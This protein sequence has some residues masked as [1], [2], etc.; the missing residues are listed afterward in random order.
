MLGG[1]GCLAF[2]G[3]GLA[4]A[5]SG[6]FDRTFS[7]N[8]IAKTGFAPGGH[9]FGSANAVAVQR[10]DRIVIAG[11][12]GQSA[13]F[14]LARFRSNGKLDRSFGDEGT[15][16]VDFGGAE[17]TAEDLAVQDD[18]RI[19]V[20]GEA[21]VGGRELIGVARL[22]PSGELD[23]SFGTGGTAIVD[24][25]DPST[26]T[27]RDLSLALGRGGEIVV[28]GT[29]SVSG[30]GTRTGPSTVCTRVTVASK[31]SASP[32]PSADSSA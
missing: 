13:N 11:S 21:W 9:G 29:A 27:W 5:A 25:F 6:D 2:A 16:R 8:G 7:G 1:L 3:A 23:P 10:N 22:R 26:E 32:A 30:P 17:E 12:T 24:P 18:G 19:L 28:G 20:V 31:A 14:G 15:V 4:L